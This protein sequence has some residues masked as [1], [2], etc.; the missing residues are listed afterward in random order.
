MAAAAMVVAARVV[1]EREAAEREAV[2]M[3]VEARAAGEIV[4]RVRRLPDLCDVWVAVEDELH[5]LAHGDDEEGA[6][7][8]LA[9]RGD[10]GVRVAQAEEVTPQPRGEDGAAL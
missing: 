2:A 1:G 3:A 6:A 7:R 8:G 5:V 4:E 10:G 9:V